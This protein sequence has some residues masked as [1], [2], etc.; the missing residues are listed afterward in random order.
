MANDGALA[1]KLEDWAVSTI[2][3]VVGNP[4]K[5]VEPYT[6]TVADGG[7]QMAQEIIAN[8]E[9]VAM[10]LVPG[11]TTTDDFEQRP[12][13]NYELIVMIGVR[14]DRG[15]GSARFG[16]DDSVGFH[17]AAEIVANALERKN[18]GVS[19]PDNVR[20]ATRV[21]HVRTVI[22]FEQKTIYVGNVIFSVRAGLKPA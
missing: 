9:P 14:N 15:D 18:P 19:D 21:R 1:S 6:G 13:R 7:A 12:D 5:T 2:K 16:D 10:P 20:I 22:L 11:D 4:F 3:A 8:R 17:R